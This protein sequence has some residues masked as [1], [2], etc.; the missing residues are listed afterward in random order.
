MQSNTQLEH[1]NSSKSEKK[2]RVQTP[3]FSEIIVEITKQ[4]LTQLIWKGNY[5]ESQHKK[6]CKQIEDLKNTLEHKEA[7]IRDLKHRLFGKKTEKNKLNVNKIKNKISGTSRSRGQQSNTS[8]HGRTERPDIPAIKETIDIPGDSCTCKQCGLP[9]SPFPGDEECDIYEIEVSAYKRRIHRKR[10]KK[11]CTCPNTIDSPGIITAPQAPKIIPRSPYGTSIWVEILLGK[12]L[13]SQPLNRILQNFKSLGLPISSGTITGGMQRIADLMKP[14]KEALYEKQM[15]ENRFHNDETR[16]EVYVFVEGKVGH[17]WYLWVTR[18]PSVIYY[19]MADNRSAK[20]PIAHYS[21]LKVEKAIIVVDRYSAYKKMVN[22][23]TGIILAFC[24]AHVRRDFIEIICSVPKLEDWGFFW[25]EEIGM[26]YHI[27]KQRLLKWQ[28]NLPLDK[29]SDEF[30]REHA[31]LKKQLKQIKDR[32]DALI[33]DDQ[34]VTK[35]KKQ[36]QLPVVTDI[37]ESDNKL[38]RVQRKVLTSLQNHW[39]G[40]IVFVEHPEVSMDNNPAEQVIRNPACGRG[41]YHGSGSIWSALLA[42]T[43]F[44]IIQTVVLWKLNI[45]H[46]LIEYLDTCAKNGGKPP[47]DISSFIPW[48]MSDDRRLHLSSPHFPHNTS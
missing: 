33:Q 22:E 27:N 17:R 11:R 15:S 1:I 46:W 2:Y 3:L 40:L 36:N 23:I 21:G 29:Q 16:W 28:E 5:Y 6:A 26:L 9:Y 44:S 39:E 12:Y 47:E 38:H 25:V 35:G 42:A 32:C 31:L 48:Q 8:G 34:A 30:N 14:I 43:M 41:V 4:E 7:Q 18:S 13:H 24:W 45:R 10:Y 20:V 37:G 19:V